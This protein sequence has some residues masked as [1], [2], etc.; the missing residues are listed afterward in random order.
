MGFELST[1]LLLPYAMDYD[2][3]LSCGSIASNLLPRL[4]RLEIIL[5]NTQYN[6]E[7]NSQEEDEH[8]ERY[9]EYIDVLTRP[10]DGHAD[11]LLTRMVSLL[12]SLAELCVR[13]YE[14]RD[15][16]FLNYIEPFTNFGGFRALTSLAVPQELLL[17]ANYGIPGQQHQPVAVHQLLPSTLERLVLFFPTVEV[18]DWLDQLRSHEACLARLGTV[19][20]VCANYR[21]DCFPAVNSHIEVWAEGAEMWFCTRVY[22][23]EEDLSPSWSVGAWSLDCDPYVM[24]VVRYLE[25]LHIK[26]E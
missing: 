14:D 19:V 4:R 5:D 13:I 23:T 12:P 6:F 25:G 1:S 15:L 16:Y 21:G 18:M 22:W 8:S 24:R 10:V 20:L 2:W 26:R 3:A 11:V 9:T 17:G 7:Y